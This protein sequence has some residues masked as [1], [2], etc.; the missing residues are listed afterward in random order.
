MLAAGEDNRT[1][2]ASRTAAEVLP[3]I[4][5]AT[6]TGRDVLKLSIFDDNAFVCAK[7]HRTFNVLSVSILVA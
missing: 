2:L 3:A 1:S 4:G 6:A 5:E 7:V